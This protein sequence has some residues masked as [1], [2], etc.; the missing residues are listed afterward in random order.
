MGKTAEVVASFEFWGALPH[1]LDPECAATGFILFPDVLQH[2]F[3][4]SPPYGM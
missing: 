2:F 3:V 4:P 1:A